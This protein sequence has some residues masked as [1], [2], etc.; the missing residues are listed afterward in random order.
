MRGPGAPLPK[1]ARWPLSDRA[2]E[3][4][5]VSALRDGRWAISSLNP[6][7]PLWNEVFA[8]RF[9]AELGV[10]HVL[11]VCNGSAALTV[12]LDAIGVCRRD[13]VLMPVLTW[14]GC[15]T[16]V[17]RVGARPRFVDIDP[18]TLC[19]DPAAV[20]RGVT[21]RTRAILA[22]HTYSSM[23]E[24]TLLRELAEERGLLLIE[25]ASHMPGAAW[26]S[27]PAGTLGDVGV[28]SFQ[29]SKLLTCGEGGCIVTNDPGLA[30]R[31]ESLSTDGR[32]LGRT[33]PGRSGRLV[34][35][36]GP[37]G[38]NY[39][40]SEIQAAILVSQLER[41]RGR[42]LRRLKRAE[43]LFRLVD[44]RESPVEFQGVY[45][46]QSK[47]AFYGLPVR[48]KKGRGS[49]SR[50][51]AMARVHRR[52]HLET[53]TLYPPI[54]SSPLFRPGP[55]LSPDGDSMVE[56]NRWA[57]TRAPIAARAFAEWLVV[58]QLALLSSTDNVD[59]LGRAILDAASVAAI[60]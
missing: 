13:E 8:K 51:E 48:L 45:A 32:R 54:P 49:K 5:A 23:A 52:C 10:K 39:C 33:S 26:K 41:L 28:F 55:S 4:A 12:A 53:E 42:N 38:P 40:L 36:G 11:P 29:S 56:R 22:V 58:P 50:D 14:V 18:R 21:P 2:T 17:L 37:M 34:P 16:S 25:D 15:A 9:A 35:G 31:S 27:R 44:E 1:W 46:A 57:Q 19:M 59:M 24:M 7:G 47:R 6:G 20:K 30:L 3:K 60:V 43:Q